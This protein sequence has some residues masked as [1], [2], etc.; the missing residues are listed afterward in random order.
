MKAFADLQEGLGPVW[1]LNSGGQTGEHV[2]IA[3]PSFALGESTLNHYAARLSALEHRYLVAMLMMNH[4]PGCRAVFLSTE[5]PTPEVIDYYFSLLP[6]D[7][8]DDFRRQFV[9]ITLPDR[10]ARSVADTLLD[11]PE[12]MEAVDC[13]WKRS[14]AARA[15]GSLQSVGGHLLAR[16]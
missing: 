3:L 4:M 14:G 2:V 9:P 13:R 11:R 12:V 8:R 7:R 16:R 10:T 6:P 15:R 1:Q 5:E